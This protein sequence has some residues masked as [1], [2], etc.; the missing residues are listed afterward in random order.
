VTA[1]LTRRSSGALGE[2]TTLN[3]RWATS[4]LCSRCGRRGLGAD[5]EL[6]ESIAQRHLRD[7]GSGES[8]GVNG[9]GQ[10]SSLEQSGVWIA[11]SEPT[12]YAPACGDRGR[13]PTQL[14]RAGRVAA[15]PLAGGPHMP[16]FP[17]F[18]TKRENCLP[19][20]K[21]RYQLRKNLKKFMEV[22]N[23]I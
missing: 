15:S 12:F 17:D 10:T 6:I 4:D 20:E 7:G 13:R 9:F 8:G 5:A 14:I 3:H 22:G 19:R 18:K 16:D 23:P 1:T 21:N 11:W 2:L